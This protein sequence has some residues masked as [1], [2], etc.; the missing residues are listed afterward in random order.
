MSSM[1]LQKRI[2]SFILNCGKRK[3]WLDPNELRGI[4]L[5]CSSKYKIFVCIIKIKRF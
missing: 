1:K 3:V 5:T 4:R 2:A